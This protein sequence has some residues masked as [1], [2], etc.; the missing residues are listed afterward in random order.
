MRQEKTMKLIVNALVDPRI[1]MT[2]NVGN[3]RAWVWSCFDYSEAK[4][5][6]EV[7]SIKFANAEVAPC[8]YGK[9]KGETKF[10]RS[11]IAQLQNT[12]AIVDQSAHPPLLPM[13]HAG[14]FKEAFDAS[15]KEMAAIAAG[16]DGV[17]SA[18]AGELWVQ[19]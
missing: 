4:L 1:V 14:K 18:E 19:K 6:E 8:G 3:D 10:T 16:A 13:Q 2:P 7:F 5:E 11:Q 15:Q 12:C 17:P 9:T